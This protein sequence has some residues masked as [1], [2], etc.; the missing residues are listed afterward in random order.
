MV[1]L[2]AWLPLKQAMNESEIADAVIA[3]VAEDCDELDVYA[4]ES[5]NH[6]GTRGWVDLVLEQ[7]YQNSRHLS[8]IE[9]KSESALEGATGANE[10]IRQFK[11]HRGFFFKGNDRFSKRDYRNSGEVNISFTLLF[12]ATDRT[13]KHVRENK[14]LYSSIEC[15]DFGKEGSYVALW[16]PDM[17]EWAHATIDGYWQMTEWGDL[18]GDVAI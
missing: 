1:P 15:R 6:Y 12:H 2:L 13:V 17:A 4:E 18:F 16:H 5:Y 8:V 9:L 7:H 3:D 11:K 14:T 10:I